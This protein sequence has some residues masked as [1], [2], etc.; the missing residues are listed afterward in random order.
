MV[1]GEFAVSAFEALA[2]VIEPVLE[3]FKPIVKYAGALAAA[4]KKGM[5]G[6]IVVVRA[7]AQVLGAVLKPVLWAIG[8]TFDFL[9]W[10]ING[11]VWL[12]EQ[13][14][15]AWSAVTSAVS[16]A[17]STVVATVTGMWN[18]IAQAAQTAWAPIGD[19]FAGLWVGITDSFNTAIG[20]ISEK[21]QWLSDTVGS[22][23]N[24]IK[25]A[26]GMATDQPAAAP[27]QRQSWQSAPGT[28][29]LMAPPM[30]EPGASPTGVMQPKPQKAEVTVD[31]K[32]LPRGTKVQSDGAK[33]GLNMSMGYVNVGY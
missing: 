32:N 1:V 20:W 12:V 6:A 22:I 4:L 5:P 16:G 23:I 28:G 11:F 24:G 29:I 9:S 18:T 10:T 25:S 31:F 2:P 27:V 21:V 3:L 30:R 7:L 19:F 15:G 33:T 14:P 8:K 17:V 13:I 26:L